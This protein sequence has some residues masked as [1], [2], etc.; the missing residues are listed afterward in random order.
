[1]GPFTRD[2]FK[3]TSS[4][5]HWI[6]QVVPL[7]VCCPFLMPRRFRAQAVEPTWSL[8]CMNPIFERI[9]QHSALSL[10]PVYRSTPI[11]SKLHFSL[12][13]KSRHKNHRIKR[14]HYLFKVNGKSCRLIEIQ[15]LT[16]RRVLSLQIMGFPGQKQELHLIACAEELFNV[17]CRRQSTLQYIEMEKMHKDKPLVTERQR[18]KAII[19]KSL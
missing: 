4:T 19:I 2:K 9:L 8:K 6:M 5:S 1:M 17:N 3:Y 10:S 18:P 7:K 16:E 11:L 15:H 12:S 13:R 14:I